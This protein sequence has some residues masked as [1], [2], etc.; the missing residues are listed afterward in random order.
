MLVF[1]MLNVAEIA[2][3]RRALL[4]EQESLRKED[5][6]GASDRSPVKLDQQAVG[7]LSRMDAMQQQAMAQASSR[8]RA[9]RIQRIDA[10]LKRIDEDEFGYC[11][12]CGEEI[13]KARLQLDPTLPTCVACARG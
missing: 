4:E 2:E 11:Q 3:F 5:V 7:R 6:A 13:G 9:G 10:A 1:A 8:R 12:D